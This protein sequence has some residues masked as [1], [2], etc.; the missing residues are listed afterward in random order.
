MLL[1]SN[2]EGQQQDRRPF[3]KVNS[4][5]CE[6]GIL[7]FYSLYRVLVQSLLC[8]PA[9][10]LLFPTNHVTAEPIWPMGL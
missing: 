3:N 9:L 5:V 4:G 7:V 6:R 2:S 10:F 1:A 8:S